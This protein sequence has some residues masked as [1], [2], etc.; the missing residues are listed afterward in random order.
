MGGKTDGSESAE[1]GD[2][3]ATILQGD[4]SV[5]GVHPGDSILGSEI[6]GSRHVNESSARNE[7]E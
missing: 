5:T 4:H 2:R 3:S 6:D 1:H 7:A